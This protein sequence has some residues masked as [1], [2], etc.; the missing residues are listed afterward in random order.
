[1]PLFEVGDD[2]LV[3]FRR[4]K[5]GP[6]LYEREIE[7]LLWSNLDASIG[8]QTRSLHTPSEVSNPFDKAR[9]VC[10]TTDDT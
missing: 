4:V 10:Q 7:D 9:H 1:M 6:D 8:G 2:Q 5:A 3:L